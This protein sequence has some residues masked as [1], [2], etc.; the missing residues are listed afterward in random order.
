MLK[1]R[2]DL[3][4]DTLVGPYT[5]QPRREYKVGTSHDSIDDTH[6]EIQ[7]ALKR[8]LVVRVEAPK[9]VEVKPVPVVVPAPKVEA[10]KPEPKKEEPKPE[11][12]KVETVVPKMVEKPTVEPLQPKPALVGNEVKSVLV[13]KPVAPSSVKS[14]RTNKGLGGK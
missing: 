4:N 1:L 8:G 2:S 14:T 9:P 13:E 10:P 5:F 6:P 11:P 3:T 7:A 12:I